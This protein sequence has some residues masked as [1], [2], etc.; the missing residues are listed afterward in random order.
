MVKLKHLFQKDGVI[1]AILE[2]LRYLTIAFNV[3]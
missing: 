1:A 3:G 2:C